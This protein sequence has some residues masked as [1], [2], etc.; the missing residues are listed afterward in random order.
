MMMANCL[1][2][3]EETKQA[4]Q[5]KFRLKDLG[6]LKH[7][8]NIR[9][10]QD[11]RSCLIYLDQKLY[12]NELLKC[13]QFDNYNSA[14]TS[15]PPNVDIEKNEQDVSLCPPSWIHCFR[16]ILG[17]LMYA[18]LGTRPDI[19]FAVSKLC[20]YQSNPSE[21][22]LELATHILRYMCGTSS[23]RLCL[24]H[25]DIHGDAL[26]GYSDADFAADKDNS[27]SVSG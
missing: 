27:R 24:G 2:L 16:S 7:Y 25:S 4:L 1:S 23:L 15:L 19:T 12:I 13:F 26:I 9:V 6:E 21:R 8:L 22:H 5:G 3:I 18:M 10:T 20:Q 11:R 14:S 17:S